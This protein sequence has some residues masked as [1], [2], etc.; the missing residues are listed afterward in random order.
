M[1]SEEAIRETAQAF[2]VQWFQEIAASEV[3]PLVVSG[4]LIG[5]TFRFESPYGGLDVE[6]SHVVTAELMESITRKLRHARKSVTFDAIQKRLRLGR[7]GIVSELSLSA[8]RGMER[9][10]Y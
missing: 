4:E 2:L 3:S 6:I 8:E 1:L 7:I 9:V 10:T 5:F